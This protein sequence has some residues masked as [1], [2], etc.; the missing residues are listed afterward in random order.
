MEWTDVYWE[1]RPADDGSVVTSYTTLT[2]VARV[3]DHGTSVARI[4]RPADDGRDD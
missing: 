1:P 3:D 2:D 4:E